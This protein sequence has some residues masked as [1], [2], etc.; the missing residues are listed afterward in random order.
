MAN[1]TAI[2]HGCPLPLG[3]RKRSS[4][5]WFLTESQRKIKVRQ[6]SNMA[7]ENMNK[8][9]FCAFKTM[10]ILIR[11]KFYTFNGLKEN[12][13]IYRRKGATTL[14]TLNLLKLCFNFAVLFIFCSQIMKISKRRRRTKER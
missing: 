1:K 5:Y 13:N 2:K 11:K 9:Y 6:E 7:G 14:F 4:I 8:S 3:K 12:K 10:Q